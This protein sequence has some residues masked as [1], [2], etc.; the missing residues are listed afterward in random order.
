MAKVT[1]HRDK[2]RVSATIRRVSL[3]PSRGPY[4]SWDIDDSKPAEVLVNLRHSSSLKFACLLARIEDLSHILAWSSQTGGRVARVEFPRLWLSFQ[5]RGGHLHCEQHSGYWLAE[6][7]WSN[8]V[9][10]LLQQFGGG[11][12]LLENSVGE[13]AILVSAAAEPVRPATWAADGTPEK[14]LPGQLAFRCGREEWLQNLDGPRHYRYDVHF[15]EMF[16]F[17]PTL[18]AGLYFL[19]CR[20]ITWHFAE[21]VNMA[22]T[23]T[24]ACTEEEKQL[25]DAMKA[26]VPDCHADAIACRL[27]LSLA[28]APYA[29]SVPWST[30]AQLLEYSRKRHLVSTSCALSL[31]QEL[32]LLKLDEVRSSKKYSKLKAYQATVEPLAACKEGRSSACGMRAG[33]A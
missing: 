3:K 16:T 12:L 10:R 17:T 27:H 11:T 24:E 5:E 2:L 19:L 28:M 26:L 13:Y 21:A 30:A 1:L 7:A 32:A 8:K 9:S 31:E 15:S 18:A 22:E 4:C 33:Y 20:F 14:L 6:R 29:T 23:I 25:W